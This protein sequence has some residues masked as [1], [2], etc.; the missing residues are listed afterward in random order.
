[1]SRAGGRRVAQRPSRRTSIS[2]SPLL[3]IGGGAALATVLTLLGVADPVPVEDNSGTPPVAAPLETVDLSC[4]A[5]AGPVTV[6]RPLAD[7]P[8]TMQLHL[9]QTAHPVEVTDQ[10]TVRTPRKPSFLTATGASAVGLLAARV[11]ATPQPTAAECTTPSGEWWFGGIGA[12]GAH[13]SELTLANPDQEAAIADLEI[14]SS[15]GPVSSNEVRGIA[16]EGGSTRAI[17]LES[18]VPQRDDLVVRIVVRQGRL[19]ASVVDTVITADGPITEQHSATAAPAERQLLPAVPANATDPVVVIGNPGESAGRAEVR[20]SGADSES[21]PLGMETIPVGAGEVVTVPLTAATADLLSSGGSSLVVEG[22]VPLAVS[23]RAQV[24]GDLVL[25]SAAPAVAG[26]SGAVLPAG[27]RRQLVLAATEQ[28]GAVTV[29]FLGGGDPWQGR[30]K[31][32]TSTTVDV[33]A[34]A[35]AVRVE[36]NVPHVGAARAWGPRGAAWL[37]LR[38][39]VVE[40]VQPAIQPDPRPD[41]D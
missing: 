32:G 7:A 28:A 21:A 8:A 24:N 41:R 22:S 36:T 10:T 33:P 25:L 31:P 38:E 40:Q 19:S 6:A 23:L 20:V 9:D 1:M 39:L 15:E 14:W 4:P 11:A 12:G 16:V 35:V 18:L 29:H 2:V 27:P 5:A 3:L 17:E 13:T 37:P 30:L 26:E 34:G